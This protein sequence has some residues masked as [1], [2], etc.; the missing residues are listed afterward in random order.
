M[1]AF[2]I[3]VDGEVKEAFNYDR[4]L[5]AQSEKGLAEYARANYGSDH[6]SPDD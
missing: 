2:M 6:A 4:P 3:E 1:D 5:S